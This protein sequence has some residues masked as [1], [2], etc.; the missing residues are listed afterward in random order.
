MSAIDQFDGPTKA[1]LLAVRDMIYE[2]AAETGAAG[3]VVEEVKWGQP[4]FATSPKT[5][6]PIRLG[7]NKAGAPTL[8]VH[9]QTT[10]VADY[11]ATVGQNAVV[12]GNR[13]VVLPEDIDAIRPL[14][15]AA[16]TYHT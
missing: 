13:A 16:L 7:L 1:K 9:C 5:G 14:V 2:V 4:S 15:R 12:E 8:F 3:K 10:L 11:V 6:T